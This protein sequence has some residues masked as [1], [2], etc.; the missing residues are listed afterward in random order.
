MRDEVDNFRWEEESPRERTP[1]E[2]TEEVDQRLQYYIIQ[3]NIERE[4]N[5]TEIDIQT[6]CDRVLTEETK[7]RCGDFSL[8]FTHYLTTWLIFLIIIFSFNL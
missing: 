2:F 8:M 3:A 5:V 4:S 7:A 1:P 6:V